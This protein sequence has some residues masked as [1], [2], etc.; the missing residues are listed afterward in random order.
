MSS[1]CFDYTQTYY[2]SWTILVLMSKTLYGANE[3]TWKIIDQRAAFCSPHQ[4]FRSLSKFS[5]HQMKYTCTY[6]Q[7]K[8]NKSD[9]RK[10]RL[11]MNLIRSIRFQF[12]VLASHQ[13]ITVTSKYECQLQWC[14]HSFHSS[15][16]ISL[17]KV[18]WT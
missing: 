10:R 7:I 15:D 2:F 17:S 3:N 1:F 13:K 6:Y 9:Y 18:R 16:R 12:D 11:N 8:I 4:T 14:G 5:P